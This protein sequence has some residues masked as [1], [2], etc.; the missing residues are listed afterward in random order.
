MLID[1]RSF[2]RLR[3]IFIF[4]PLNVVPQRL[5]LTWSA[6][7]LADYLAL[8]RLVLNYFSLRRRTI[9]LS[10]FAFL[11]RVLR[12]RA[13]LPHGVDGALRPTGALPSPP[14]CG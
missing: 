8:M 10:D 9:S 6:T 14:P 3:P 4:S 13:G 7:E 12:P 2:L 5:A 11:L 1:E